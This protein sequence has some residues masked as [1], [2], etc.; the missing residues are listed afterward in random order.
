MLRVE[1]YAEIRR[2]HRDGM[3]IR[4]IARRFNHSKKT[5]RKALATAEPQRYRRSKP[6]PAP[7]LDPFKARIDAI[8]TED[9][10]APF[11]QRHTAA[12]LFRRLCAWPAPQ[13]LVQVL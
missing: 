1:H 11:K 13:N 2:A 6:H 9:E 7:K 10:Q 4:E 8:L 5:V 12:Q 3:S